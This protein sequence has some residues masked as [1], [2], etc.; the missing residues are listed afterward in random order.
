MGSKIKTRDQFWEHFLLY[1]GIMWKRKVS[2]S[3]VYYCTFVGKWLRLLLDISK[4]FTQG[5]YQ[6]QHIQHLIISILFYKDNVLQI[7]TSENNGEISPI[8]SQIPVFFGKWNTPL[9]SCHST[10]WLSNSNY[11]VP[12]WS[13]SSFKITEV[14]AFQIW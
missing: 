1:V 3:W 11:I 13:E 6:T 8:S 10:D 7:R 14:V 9:W 12:C 5:F 2:F 4:E